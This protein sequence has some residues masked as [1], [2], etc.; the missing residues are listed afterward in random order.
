MLLA[1]GDPIQ[2]VSSSVS[3]KGTPSFRKIVSKGSYRVFIRRREDE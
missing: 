2:N 3:H 1:D